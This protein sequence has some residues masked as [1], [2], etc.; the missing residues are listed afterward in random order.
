MSSTLA[1]SA[2]DTL[3]RLDTLLIRKLEEPFGAANNVNTVS[4]KTFSPYAHVC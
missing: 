1:S 2:D 4:E 3:A